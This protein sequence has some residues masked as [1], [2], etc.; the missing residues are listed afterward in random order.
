MPKDP[1][2]SKAA[3]ILG[4]VKTPKKAASSAENGR[5]NVGKRKPAKKNAL[6]SKD[7]ATK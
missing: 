1:L 4:R 6:P 2:L 7:S 3:G 5:K